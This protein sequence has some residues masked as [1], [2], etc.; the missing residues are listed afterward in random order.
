MPEKW[1]GS[2][3]EDI[4]AYMDW[5]RRFRDAVDANKITQ[6]EAEK[7]VTLMSDERLFQLA[8]AQITVLRAAS[9]NYLD[10]AKADNP[11]FRYINR[12]IQGMIRPQITFQQLAAEC[13]KRRTSD[14]DL[15]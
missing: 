5:I 3:R 10:S 13:W 14:E 9:E 8:K 11:I 12:G 4:C 15:K 2:S 7:F 6:P 1:K